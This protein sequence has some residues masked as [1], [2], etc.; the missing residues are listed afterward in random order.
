MTALRQPPPDD[1]SPSETSPGAPPGD[2]PSVGTFDATATVADFLG[3]ASRPGGGA[4]PPPPPPPADQNAP[5]RRGRPPGKVSAREKRRRR[6][7]AGRKAAETKKANDAGRAQPSSPPQQPIGA[8]S[9][10]QQQQR[11]NDAMGFNAI[12]FTVAVAVFGEDMLPTPEE[13]QRLDL[14]LAEF[15]RLHPDFK[16]R[17]ELVLLAAYGTFVAARLDRPRVQGRMMLAWHWIR[18]TVSKIFGKVR[19]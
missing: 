3:G 18:S 13:R 10:Q 1:Q 8:S 11:L 15:L 9:D 4:A 16:P 5:R 2:P 7:E 19:L 6:Q 12:F 17:P 14:A